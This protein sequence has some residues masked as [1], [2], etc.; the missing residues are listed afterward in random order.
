MR[1]CSVCG[2]R[3]HLHPRL[4]DCPQHMP[5]LTGADSNGRPGLVNSISILENLTRDFEFVSFPLI[6]LPQTPLADNDSRFPTTPRSLPRDP[7]DS[8]HTGHPLAVWR[9]LLSALG[10]VAKSQTW[11]AGLRASG[12]ISRPTPR[13]D[14]TPAALLAPTEPTRAPAPQHR[15]CDPSD[16][17]PDRCFSLHLALKP[18]PSQRP[19][20]CHCLVFDCDPSVK[21]TFSGVLASG[22]SC[23]PRP[24]LPRILAHP[25]P[26][27]TP[28]RAETN[29]MVISALF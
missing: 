21:P 24:A 14:A 10:S 8:N 5:E 9:G 20:P 4:I 1:L 28:A 26:P 19:V 12:P 13:V 18:G 16:S 6:I 2:W 22:L 29:M 23:A 25:S 7:P 27:G 11:P 15:S 3:R 17:D